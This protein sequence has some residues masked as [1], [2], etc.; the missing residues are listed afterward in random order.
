MLFALFA[1]LSIVLSLVGYIAAL[2]LQR[3][4]AAVLVVHALLF[5]LSNGFMGQHVYSGI[6]QAF[7][8]LYTL[9]L[10]ASIVRLYNL[11]T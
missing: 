6:T 4:S 5:V 2:C 1:L 3:W 10:G 11:K 7:F 9:L 8:L